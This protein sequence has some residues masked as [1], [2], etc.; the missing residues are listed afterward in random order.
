[1][2]DK[3][4]AVSSD[5]V[6]ERLRHLVDNGGLDCNDEVLLS[7][8]VL[9][10]EGEGIVFFRFD[11]SKGSVETSNSGR[12]TEESQGLVNCGQSI[13]VNR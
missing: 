13:W 3:G 1:V 7:T 12:S 5:E 6:L 2:F 9:K 8:R 4:T 11:T 10:E